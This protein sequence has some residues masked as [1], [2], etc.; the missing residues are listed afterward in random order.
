MTLITYA[1]LGLMLLLLLAAGYVLNGRAI[2]RKA[3]ALSEEIENYIEAEVEA[4]LEAARIAESD[5][6][7]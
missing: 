6:G 1:L 5:K 4:R 3:L 2:K 7:Q